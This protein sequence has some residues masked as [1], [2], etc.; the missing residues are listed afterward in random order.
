MILADPIFQGLAISLMAGEIATPRDHFF[1]SPQHS[2]HAMGSDLKF[3]IWN[4][5]LCGLRPSHDKTLAHTPLSQ[6]FSCAKCSN[7]QNSGMRCFTHTLRFRIFVLV[8]RLRAFRWSIRR[9][10]PR[11]RPRAARAEQLEFHWLRKI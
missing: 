9:T 7:E 5:P 1:R 2:R 11:R 6:D 10:F 4:Q 3:W 8:R